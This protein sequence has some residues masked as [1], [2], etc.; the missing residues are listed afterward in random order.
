MSDYEV[1][2]CPTGIE[3]LDELLEGGFPRGRVILLA[4]DCGTGKSILSTQF[5]HNGALKYDEPGVLVSLEQSPRMLKQDM[6]F[7]GF[8]LEKMEEEGKLVIIDAS[9]SGVSGKSE[10]SEFKLSPDQFSLDSILALIKEASDKIGA[11]RA[12]V[13]S[14]SAL[15]SILETKKVHVGTGLKEDVRLAILGINYKL[16]E[17]GL[18][19]LLISDIL[20]DGKLSKH[21]IEEFMVDGV[22]TLHYKAVGSDSGRHLMIKKMR[23]TRHSENINMIEFER[24]RGIKV[25]SP[26]D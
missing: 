15:D 16:Q 24:G 26:G 1:V 21:G 18:T 23:S 14:F 22:I 10:K 25:V 17:M 6:G 4:G 3:G 19:S 2:R 11:K 8:D 5:L 9:L 20:D 13:D 12:V 7:M